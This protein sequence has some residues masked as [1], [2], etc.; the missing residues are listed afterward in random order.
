M[1]SF[2]F[3]NHFIVKTGIIFNVYRC[4]WKLY[5]QVLYASVSTETS[6]RHRSG[7][8]EVKVRVFP[9]QVTLRVGGVKLL[10]PH[11]EMAGEVV[12]CKQKYLFLKHKQLKLYKNWSIFQ[13]KKEK[14]HPAFIPTSNLPRFFF[15]QSQNLIHY[16]F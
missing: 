9:K 14:L 2:V 7:P 16:F 13:K 15:I 1:L 5:E 10:S 3:S 12:P 11:D 6:Y 8:Q 4:D